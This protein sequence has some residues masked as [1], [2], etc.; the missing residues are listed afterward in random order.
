MLGTF[1]LSIHEIPNERKKL[2]TFLQI[3]VKNSSS[4]ST[5]EHDCWILSYCISCAHAHHWWPRVALSLSAF[6]AR[7]TYINSKLWAGFKKRHLDLSLKSRG[8]PWLWEKR[9]LSW[10]KIIVE[11][12]S[13]YQEVLLM[14]LVWMEKSWF[15]D[16]EKCNSKHGNQTSLFAFGLLWL[17][18]LSSGLNPDITQWWYKSGISI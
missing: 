18:N 12:L 10:S 4:R 9:S 15:N 2:K 17:H 5:S 1:F 7:P 6:R 11:F 14:K 13:F 3:F 16:G 8:W